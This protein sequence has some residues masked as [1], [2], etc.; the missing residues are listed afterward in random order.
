[1][2]RL[3]RIG[4]LCLLLAAPLAHAAQVSL[5]VEGLSGQLQQNVRATLSTIGEDE[6]SNDGRFRVRAADAIRQGLRALGYFQPTIE[7]E[8]RPGS[9]FSRPQLIAN[10]M[11]GEPVRIAGIN[12]RIRGA[13]K[14][15]PAYQA[16]LAKSLPPVG[17]VL[18]QGDYDNLKNALNSLALQ[19][20][21]FGATMPVHQLGVIEDQH[22]AFWDIEFDSGP[23]YRFGD[24]RFSGSQIQSAYLQ[25]LRPFKTGE[26]YSADDLAKFSGNLSAT[27]WFNSVVV[28]PDF[29]AQGADQTLPLQAVV[30]PRSQ[31][32]VD[33]GGGY[34]TDVG[35][36]M[37][38]S[39]K[40]PW[41]NSYGH[42]L[43]TSLNLSM[44]EQTADFSY[45]IPLLKAPLE[46]YYLVQGGFQRTDLND[47]Q[48][49][50]TTLNLARYWELSSGWQRGINMRWSLD[51]FTQG[52]LTETAMLLYPGVS[53]NRTRSRGGL[54]PTW[55]DT[56]RY[57][58]D[59]SNR[60]WGSSVDF[61]V[62]Q[63]QNV[64]IRTLAER[65][66]FVVRGN[67]GWIETNDF[68]KVPPSLRFFA[69]GDRSIRGYKYKSIS[70]RGSDGKLTGASR[71]ATGSLEYQYNLSGKW[72]GGVFVD[73][74][75]A[76]ND[77][78]K[79][80]FHTGTGVGVIWV[81]PVGPI[82]LNLGV[83]VG[84]EDK[85]DVQIYIGLGPEL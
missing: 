44:P 45:K 41:M 67:L 5:V 16:L 19:R 31:N 25:N 23:R 51:H 72:W 66:R 35:P 27:N 8:Y 75:E 13:A 63:A 7:F 4:L 80:D 37:K 33:L 69:G 49:D 77:F 1:M 73:S 60:Y 68:N 52:N 84:R 83:P 15:D 65:H 55:G 18:D 29:K 36:R 30:T 54:M 12:V 47:T 28:S 57:S 20:G 38:V 81:S 43:D 64:W 61:A 48:S 53:V 9:T 42:S 3:R 21:Y 14:D 10:V 78:T 82:R 58:V 34:A 22:K 32:M 46:Q 76:V 74:G 56:Q 11:P 50:S 2:P 85:H 40:R 26:Y 71:L 62:F 39:W 6:I 70:P 17:S 24:V 59:V 79:S